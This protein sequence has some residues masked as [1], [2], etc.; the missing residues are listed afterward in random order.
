MITSKIKWATAPALAVLVC[1]GAALSAQDDKAALMLPA[2]DFA[3][4]QRLDITYQDPKDM[5]EL[6]VQ[7]LGLSPRDADYE[8]G[9]NPRN[10]RHKVVIATVTNIADPLV[11]AVQWRIEMK[12]DGGYWEAVEAG[13]RRKCKNGPNVN[14][15][16]RELCP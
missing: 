4:M 3:P 1:T 7:T 12:A 5:A 6:Y 10:T 8:E 14:T 9:R 13:L 16:T 15:W 2:S 11:N